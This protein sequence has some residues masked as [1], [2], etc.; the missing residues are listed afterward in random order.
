MDPPA[1]T[2][3]TAF[4]PSYKRMICCSLN[5]ITRNVCSMD[6][7]AATTIA[8]LQMDGTISRHFP[9]RHRG[10]AEKTS[11]VTIQHHKNVLPLPHA[12]KRSE[13]LVRR[14]SV[15]RAR[16]KPGYRTM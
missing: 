7:P 9:T 8:L 15:I 4:L 3:T 14:H 10:N 2:S 5:I 12:Y 6:L 16:R 13:L 1:A 11:S